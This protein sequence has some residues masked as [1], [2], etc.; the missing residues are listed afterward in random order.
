MTATAKTAAQPKRRI[1][2]YLVTG[3]IG[4]GGMGM[5]YRGLDEVLERE[6]A[7]KTL[8][9]EGTL[10]EESRKRFEIEAKAA[11]KLQHPNILT[12]FEL[13]EDRGMPFIAME[14]LPGVDLEVLLRS[15]EAF[16]LQEKLEIAIQ[17][18]RG[19]AFAHEHGIVHRDIKPS[20]VRILDDGTV[21]ILDF[22]IAKLS[23][24]N[25]TKSG[26][27]VGTVHYMSPEQI[28][29]RSLDGR[30]DV[31]S[32]GVILH[33]LLAG[34]RPFSG[35]GP[36][37]VLY[38]IVHDPAP[39]LPI[40]EL[41]E[42]G[43]R[44]Q[45]ITSRSLEKEPEARYPSAAAMVEDL[46]EVLARY[47]RS[48]ETTVSTQDLET[49]SLARRILKEGRLEDGQRRLRE[50]V[51]RSPYSV[52]ARRALRTASRELLRREGP[53][54]PA[55]EDFSELDAT[56]QASPTRR[57]RETLL[58]PAVSEVPAGTA[59]AEGRPG[60]GLIL[61]LLGVAALALLAAV[62]LLRDR[63]GPPPTLASRLAVR[64]RPPGAAV[65]VD[66]KDTGLR[67][68]GQVELPA[69]GRVVVTLRKPG[70]RDA[71]RTLTLPLR[72]DEEL[73][74]DLAASEARLPVITDP[75]GAAVSLDG[76]R[77]AG[78]TPLDLTLDPTAEHRL[79]FSLDGHRPK[80]MV[81]APGELPAEVR[82]ALEPAG[83]LGTV[84]IASSYPLEVTWRG[85]VLAQGQAS[86]RV[87]LPA[88]RQTLS[89]ASP[90]VFLR[91]TLTLE[92]KPGGESSISAPGLG[93]V[94]IR[95]NPDNCQVYI[96]GSF[97]DYPP[98][99]EKPVAA[100]THSVSFRWADGPRHEE[101]FE[102]ARG[103]VAFVTGRR[104]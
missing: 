28:R 84:A 61:M 47:T 102:V 56:F 67:T 50:I 26:M 46:A 42:V 12:V 76:R 103:G 45:E 35:E 65:L 23:G 85:R 1:G 64:S 99:I 20:N 82:V 59:P 14:L 93:K 53:G 11:A 8:T 44:L 90:G 29:G 40:P 5:V 60:R 38:K 19:L 32:V 80:Q 68:D 87:S 33:E 25:V 98:I 18:L 52:E 104:D 57:A 69:S 7:V 81:L 37:E 70:Y 58:Q 62:Y 94:S 100:G 83:P 17:V 13:G 72:Q 34:R 16:L 97:V 89:L 95:A 55:A 21:K 79:A 96:D 4:R 22:G 15:G 10:D 30:S 88:G 73:V 92:V 31:F 27:M 24:T 2:R 54:E 86:P 75:A 36:T 51:A 48:L 41:G 78:T 3:R 74:L 71:V 77:L 6:V 43:P 49:M 9:V 63:G 91:S 101:S 66:G 39:P